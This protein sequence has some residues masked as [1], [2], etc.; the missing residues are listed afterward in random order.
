MKARGQLMP[1][2]SIMSRAPKSDA[3]IQAA[4]GYCDAK[5]GQ[6][7]DY[8]CDHEQC[9]FCGGQLLSCGCAE[10]FFY[11]K[12]LNPMDPSSYVNGDVRSQTPLLP[13]FGLPKRV[14]ENGLSPAQQRKW[15]RHLEAEGR[16][17]FILWPNI[18][19]RC[20]ETWPEMF[21]VSNEEWEKY[22]SLRNRRKMLCR[23]CLAYI[24]QLIDTNGEPNV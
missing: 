12:A 1:V 18:C 7:H 5:E 23:G 2:E 15:K 21:M 22:V 11:P 17:P 16:V 4:C 13:Y 9:P 8:L 19:G 24:K 6:L 14:Y 20:G 10:K 3:R